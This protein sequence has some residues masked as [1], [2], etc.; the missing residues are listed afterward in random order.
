M[1]RCEKSEYKLISSA[2]VDYEILQMPN[3]D[4][5]DAVM[6]LSKIAIETIKLNEQ[7][8]TR[9]K[10]IEKIKIKPYDALHLAFAESSKVD[11]FLTTDDKLIK[12]ATKIDFNFS[13][14]N[15]LSFIYKK[16]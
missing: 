15:P 14:L 4:K 3:K 13:I 10:V 9:A 11:A 12:K 8:I 16:L 6:K 2:I 1:D 7:I 5:Q